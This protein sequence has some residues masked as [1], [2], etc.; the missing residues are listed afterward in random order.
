MFNDVEI[1]T[2]QLSPEAQYHLRVLRAMPNATHLLIAVTLLTLGVIL[3]TKSMALICVM[4]M[5]YIALVAT[6]LYLKKTEREYLDYLHR[7]EAGKD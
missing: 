3:V 5:L 6:Y 7:I 2:K 4:S 1:D